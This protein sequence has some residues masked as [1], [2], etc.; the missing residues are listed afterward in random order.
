M[1]YEKI[2]HLNKAS[3]NE[4]LYVYVATR[5]FETVLF[6]KKSTGDAAC[7]PTLTHHGQTG[8]Q[9]DRRR[10]NEQSVQRERASRGASVG[11]CSGLSHWPAF[12]AFISGYDHTPQYTEGVLPSLCCFD[13]VRR[14]DVEI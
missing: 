6:T 2:P 13:T 4:S 14:G 10:S 11:G 1:S 9:R 5:H 8:E 7:G 12:T 3:G